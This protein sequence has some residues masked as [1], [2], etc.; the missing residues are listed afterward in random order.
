MFHDDRLLGLP[1]NLIEVGDLPRDLSIA[2]IFAVYQ[3]EADFVF[4]HILKA[5]K[6]CSFTSAVIVENYVVLRFQ[7]LKA[8]ILH[9]ILLVTFPIDSWP[10]STP[11]QPPASR[12]SG[13]KSS[14]LRSKG[15]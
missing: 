15:M 11:F 9:S 7:E 1:A 8:A 12:R 10:K 14:A 6:I 3:G 13:G 5:N 2:S 4:A